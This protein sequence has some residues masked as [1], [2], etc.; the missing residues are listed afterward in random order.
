[1]Q[2]YTARSDP[3]A[4]FFTRIFLFPHKTRLDRARFPDFAKEKASAAKNNLESRGK[5]KRKRAAAHA[6]TTTQKATKKGPNHYYSLSPSLALA[7]KASL[8]PVRCSGF[9]LLR[10]VSATGLFILLLLR[11][12]PLISDLKHDPFRC[13][14]LTDANIKD[15]TFGR[16]I[17]LIECVKINHVMI[18][19]SLSLSLERRQ[20]TLTIGLLLPLCVLLRP[21]TNR[22][23]R[24]M[25]H[26]KNEILV[27]CTKQIFLLVRLQTLCRVMLKLPRL[28]LFFYFS[29]FLFYIC[30]ARSLIAHF[31]SERCYISET[32]CPIP[33]GNNPLPPPPALIAPQAMSFCARHVAS[34]VL[35]MSLAMTLIRVTSACLSSDALPVQGTKYGDLMYI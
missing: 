6:T 31:L 34:A 27:G 3:S 7:L 10:F 16:N 11:F 5:R 24:G 15:A 9:F 25:H 28:L 29:F 12:P 21:E 30:N 19:C 23:Y 22:N 20:S 32:G 13:P 18:R 2:Q 1:M 33:A 26:Y 8:P 35:H 4:P 17:S 14:E